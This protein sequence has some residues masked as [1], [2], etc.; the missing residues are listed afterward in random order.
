M[1]M[2][3]AI[4][5]SVIIGSILGSYVV[6]MIMPRNATM[7]AIELHTAIDACYAR[8]GNIKIVRNARNEVI[9]FS[10]K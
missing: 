1:K 4:L 2:D 7:T 6:E 3:W 9:E 8:N 10:C 5:A